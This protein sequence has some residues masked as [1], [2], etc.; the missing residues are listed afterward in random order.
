VVSFVFLCSRFGRGCRFA[1]RSLTWADVF[2]F[3]RLAVRLGLTAFRAYHHLR[4]PSSAA[5]LCC[6]CTIT[7]TAAF[8]LRL[9][10]FTYLSGALR[11]PTSVRYCRFLHSLFV[12]LLTTYGHCGG[13]CLRT[14]TPF[15]LP[16]T[17]LLPSARAAPPSLPG[18]RHLPPRTHARTLFSVGANAA[19]RTYATIFCCCL[20]AAAVWFPRGLGMPRH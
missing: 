17:T 20:A 18:L 13:H 5:F 16:L 19:L 4:T 11:A 3:I 12:K 10:A 14:G 1:R 2:W 7:S 15:C 8:Y 6:S 9:P